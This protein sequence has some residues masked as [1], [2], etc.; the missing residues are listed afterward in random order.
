M[1][2][3]T[4]AVRE[5]REFFVVELVREGPSWRTIGVLVSPEDP[6]CLMIDG[7]MPNSLIAE[8]NERHQEAQRV[9]TGSLIMSVNGVSDNADEML[10]KLQSLGRGDAYISG[11]V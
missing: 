9:K 5:E 10:A 4:N 6:K 2:C 8:W 3:R 1:A 11:K 7:I